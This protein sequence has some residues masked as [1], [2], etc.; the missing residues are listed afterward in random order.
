MNLRLLEPYYI[1]EVSNASYRPH[2]DYLKSYLDKLHLDRFLYRHSLFSVPSLA[3]EEYPRDIL[4][5]LWQILSN[6]I[7]VYRR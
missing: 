2:L 3:K 1:A 6:A 7:Y 4:P 5:H